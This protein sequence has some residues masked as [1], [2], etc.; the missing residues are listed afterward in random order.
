MFT[1]IISK[2]ASLLIVPSIQSY[3]LAAHFVI[4]MSI[5][6]IKG[7]VNDYRAEVLK[8]DMSE[9]QRSQKNMFLR[10]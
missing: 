10:K 4:L 6:S 5:K 1:A 9:G 2:A 8:S 7:E 3:I